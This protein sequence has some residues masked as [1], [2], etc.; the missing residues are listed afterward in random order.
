MGSK[1]Y[2]DGFSL[3]LYVFS[4]VFFVRRLLRERD[5]KKKFFNISQTADVLGIIFIH[6]RGELKLIL[7]WFPLKLYTVP[8]FYFF[9]RRLLIERRKNIFLIFV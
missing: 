8:V 5:W 9:A 7:I 6:E 1:A 3:N 2:S 4:D